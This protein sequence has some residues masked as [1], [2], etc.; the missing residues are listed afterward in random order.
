MSNFMRIWMGAALLVLIAGQTYAATE[1]ILNFKS[2]ISIHADATV[3]VIETIEV[4]AT[5]NQIKRGIYR[6][7]PTAYTDAQGNTVQAGFRVM[8]VSRGGKTIDFWVEKKPGSQRVYMGNKSFRVKPGVHTFQLTYKTDHQIGYFKDYDEIYWNVTGDQWAFPIRRA[9]AIVSLPTGANVV[10]QAAYTGVRGAKGQSFTVSSE[11]DGSPHFITS[12]ALNPGEGLTVAVAWPK[13]FVNEPSDGAKLTHA[14]QSNL[15]LIV[16]VVG[17]L[18]VLAYYLFAW[19]R[20]GRDPVAGPVVPL[21]APPKGYS[22]AASHY[23]LNMG[24]SDTAFSAAVVSLAV[25]GALKIDDRNGTF[26]LTQTSASVGDLSAGEKALASQ[27]FRTQS[28]VKLDQKNHKIIGG[29]RKALQQKIDGEFEGALFNNNF[30][31]L[32][33]GIILSL[34]TVIA[35]VLFSSGSEEAIFM[36]V[37]LSVWTIACGAL[38]RKVFFA[39]KAARNDVGQTVAAI[40]ISL[41][42]LPFLG[43]EV[44]GL[45]MLAKILS[46]PT[47]LL[48]ILIFIQA[49][50]FHFLMK[51]PTI[52]GRRI[53]DQIEGFKLYLSVAE[54]H[55]LAFKHPPDETPELFE[56]YLPYALALGVGHEWS[57]RF[58]NLLS[59]AAAATTAQHPYQPRWYSGSSWNSDGISGLGDNLNKSFSNALSSS[60]ASPRSSGSGGGGSSGGGGGGGGG[61]GF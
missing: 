51:A 8:G 32:I 56:T 39:W 5:G 48:M 47:A 41:F 29:A 45:S 49:P 25:K 55:Q 27:L 31:Y 23:A 16:A 43:G 4:R 60:A 54:K 18:I 34:I 19:N 6:D 36:V 40:F 2:N 57:S 24:F 53:M 46:W 50:I 7:F 35:V 52:K 22:P 12:K 58:G 59:N 1:E 42:S 26:T 37:W 44:M 15:H 38:I 3:T 33:P 10:Q 13:G 21:F 17:V 61:G 30:L 20:I 9:E 28:S 14:L 11:P